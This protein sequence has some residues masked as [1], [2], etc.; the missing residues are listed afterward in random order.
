M[1]LLSRP[2]R[3]IANGDGGAVPGSPQP[4]DDCKLNT[5]GIVIVIASFVSSKKV[6]ISP[7]AVFHKVR[8]SRY[9]GGFK[10]YSASP[11]INENC[12]QAHPGMATPHGRENKGTRAAN[13]NG[14]L[15]YNDLAHYID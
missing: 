7:D 4:E 15:S 14:H 1:L 2:S 3:A 8:R 5:Q 13:N 10:G 11:C 9:H 12:K 6:I